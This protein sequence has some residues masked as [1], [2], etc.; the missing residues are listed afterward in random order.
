MIK[1]IFSVVSEKRKSFLISAL[2]MGIAAA[3]LMNFIS[4]PGLLQGEILFTET[5][6]LQS[7]IFF[8]IFIF[9]SSTAITL[10]INKARKLSGKGMGIA[11]MF[12]GLFTSA[13]PICYPLILTAA[14]I[15]TALAVLPFGG[16]EFQLL[17]IVLLLVSIY[18]SAKPLVCKV[19]KP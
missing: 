8:I 17:S 11:G 7:I 16:A 1:E 18:F 12:A 13:C 4:L 6:T 14:G 3:F 9:L 2:I 19:E 15:P 5:T 10:N